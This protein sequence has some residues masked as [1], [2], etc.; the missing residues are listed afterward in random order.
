MSNR[1]FLSML[2]VLLISIA[3]SAQS[4]NPG[5]QPSGNV[6][7]PSE[8]GSV[9]GTVVTPQGRPLEYAVRITVQDLRGSPITVFTDSQG[10]FEMR[11]VP[12]GSYNVEAESG[13]EHFDS[14]V[15]QIEVNKQS[16]TLVTISLKEKR[17]ATITQPGGTVISAGE[18]D[19]NVPSKARDEF[20]KGIKAARTD[21]R[22]EAIS[23]FRK[24]IAIYPRYLAAH[25]DLGAQLL[26]Q[27]SFDEA[28][29]EFEAA[30]AIDPNAFNP[31]LNLGILFCRTHQ[32][33]EA[34][35]RLD[36]AISLKSD[37]AEA[38]YYRGQAHAALDEKDEAIKDLKT[39]HNLG[40]KA[41][42][43]ALYK[44]GEVYADMNDPSQAVGYFE[45]YLRES[46]N[47]V[48]AADAKRMINLLRR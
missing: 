13:D 45:A 24:A 40:G 8:S 34:R 44:L 10:R 22:Q 7:L 5:R 48:N 38:Y 14:G 29:A 41:L 19:Q 43:I 23:A 27:G 21:K 46:P 42:S 6:G 39:S 16:T 25:N 35:A 17:I 12:V 15:A 9:V 3:A 26:E 47:G 11:G 2:T 31:I 28:Q 30:L 32:F 37:S 18:A 20:E 36:N 4:T 1:L 33:D